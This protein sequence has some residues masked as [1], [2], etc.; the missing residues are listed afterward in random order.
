[1]ADKMI[2]SYYLPPIANNNCLV[3]LSFYPSLSIQ[4]EK[5]VPI[6]LFAMKMEMGIFPT[7]VSEILQFKT[8]FYSV[9]FV[10]EFHPDFEE[11]ILAVFLVSVLDLIIE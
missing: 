8:Q 3:S 4:S 5:W 6:Q 2:K 11:K 1:M 7:E 10:I 9:L